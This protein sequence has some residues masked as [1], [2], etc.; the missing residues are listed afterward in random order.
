MASKHSILTWLLCLIV[1]HPAGSA[2]NSIKLGEI[3]PLSGTLAKHGLEIHQGVELA[4]AEVNEAGGLEG[5]RLE[6]LWR[7]DQSRPDVA[8]SR[9]EELCGRK[10]VLALTTVVP[11]V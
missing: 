5:H 1:L 8:I 2:A 7:D 11:A 9:A 6:L 10:N 4:I 3:N